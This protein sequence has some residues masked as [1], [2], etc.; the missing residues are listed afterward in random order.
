MVASMPLIGSACDSGVALGCVCAKRNCRGEFALGT[1]KLTRNVTPIPLQE[2]AHRLHGGLLV[3][4]A[5]VMGKSESRLETTP[6]WHTHT[7][8]GHAKV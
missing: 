3:V 6:T 7:H 4:S 2:L 1:N 8:Q 5:C